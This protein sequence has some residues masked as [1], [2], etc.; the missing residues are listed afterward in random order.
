MFAILP[1]KLFRIDYHF[2]DKEEGF[3]A[4]NMKKINEILD[5]VEACRVNPSRT[6]SIIH[7]YTN[8]GGYDDE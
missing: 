2:I 1:W 3:V 4:S 6:A 8:P 7:S 5:V